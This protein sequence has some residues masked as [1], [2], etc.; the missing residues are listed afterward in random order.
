M[1]AGGQRKPEA[2]PAQKNPLLHET[3]KIQTPKNRS[4]KAKEKIIAMI[5][6]AVCLITGM[7]SAAFVL[8]CIHFVPRSLHRTHPGFY[9]CFRESIGI[10]DEHG[11]RI[12]NL[13]ASGN[14]D[15]MHICMHI[16]FDGPGVRKHIGQ[17]DL[18]LVPVKLK[19]YIERIKANYGKS[20]LQLFRE[21]ARKFQVY[22]MSDKK[23]VIARYGSFVRTYDN[24]QPRSEQ[25]VKEEDCADVEAADAADSVANDPGDSETAA[26]EIPLRYTEADVKDAP[27]PAA[28]DPNADPTF[29]VLHSG[30]NDITVVSHANPVFIIFDFALK[31]KYRVL[32]NPDLQAI[33]PD[34]DV[35]YFIDELWPAVQ[36]WY[37]T[38]EELEAMA[39]QAKTADVDVSRPQP[40]PKVTGVKTEAPG[41]AAPMHQ[42]FG[43]TIRRRVG[44]LE[45]LR[46]VKLATLAEARQV[47]KARQTRQISYGSGGPAGLRCLQI[48]V[49]LW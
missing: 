34:E 6:F 8:H 19:K 42:S 27:A 20:Y 12:L 43:H 7:F 47:A 31:M 5:G 28:S 23:H 49:I 15:I 9:D 25:E 26:Y 21:K 11:N 18:A 48:G 16:I 41:K 29:H 10:L 24:L 45:C 30:A 44:G 35:D 13:D 40:M 3:P 32:D 36:H 17:G 2:T 38:K 39:S 1:P 22:G 4:P 37:Y 14:Q 33:L 46:K